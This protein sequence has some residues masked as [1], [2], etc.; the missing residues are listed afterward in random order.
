MGGFYMFLKKIIIAVCFFVSACGFSPLYVSNDDVF[1]APS[2]IE[3]ASI[4]NYHGY[5]LKQNLEN[6]FNPQNKKTN[7]KYILEVSLKS[8]SL[9]SQSIQGD[10]FA[11][12]KKVTLK[13]DYKLLDKETRKVLL[14][15]STRAIGGFNV[16]N[17]PYATYQAEKKQVD[18]LVLIVAN[19]ISTRVISYLKKQETVN[20]G[21]TNSD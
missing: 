13:A 15:S 16:F 2:E 8:P 12:R 14:S 5:I 17:E 21:E 4:P 10:N 7:K 19:N 11:S 18:D 9:A 20:E 6:S 1:S 3:V